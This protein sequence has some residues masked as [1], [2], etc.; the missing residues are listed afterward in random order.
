[1]TNKRA[2]IIQW[3]ALLSCGFIATQLA[4]IIIK[5]EAFCLNQGCEII[6]SLTLVPPLYFNLAG[7]LFFLTVFMASWWEQ[8]QSQPG[9]DWLRLLLLSGLAAEG[10]LVSYQL[11]VVQTLCSYCLIIFGLIVLLNTIYGR[12][13][14]L[15]GIPIFLAVLIS[16]GSLNFGSA[17][18]MLQSPS[19]EAGTFAVKGQGGQTQQLYLFFSS[20]CTHCQNVLAAIEGDNNC[21]LNFNPIDEIDSLEVPD[22]KYSTSYNPAI[23]RLLLSLFKIKTIP[24]L[25]AKQEP[26]FSLIK[27]EDAIVEFINKT[28]FDE[29][30]DLYSGSSSDNSTIGFSQDTAPA[31]ECEIEVACPDSVEQSTSSAY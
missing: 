11:F 19:L 31:G 15:L 22:L 1:M 20:D 18:I 5:G 8:N 28:C 3:T 10:V 4:T 13:Q 23:N 6:E 12:K 26:D 2:R 30:P 21:E 27:G 7:F 14:L 9:F 16:F 17:Q 29:Q 25:L 24:V